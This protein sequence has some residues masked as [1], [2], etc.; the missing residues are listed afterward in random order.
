MKEEII[1][2]KFDDSISEEE[3]NIEIQ[4][5][6]EIINIISMNFINKNIENKDDNLKLIDDI[7]KLDNIFQTKYSIYYSSLEL[8]HFIFLIIYER[9]IW[10][11]DYNWNFFLPLNISYNHEITLEQ[12]FIE[13][14]NFYHNNYLKWKEFIQYKINFSNHFLWNEINKKILEKVKQFIFENWLV[15]P[16]Y[17]FQYFIYVI[18]IW[19]EELVTL[20]SILQKIIPQTLLKELHSW[21]P[22]KINI[23]L[24]F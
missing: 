13:K 1:I 22:S 21:N 23:L 24:F 7:I 14:M 20:E 4:D 5:L 12:T 2:E 9:F 17:N 3:A 6:K 19:K 16:Q 11:I 10:E 15:H 18:K 8:D